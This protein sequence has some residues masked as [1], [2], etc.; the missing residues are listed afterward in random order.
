VVEVS[1]EEVWKKSEKPRREITSEVSEQRKSERLKLG[2][3][4]KVSY[5]IF[6]DKR[7]V[8][9]RHGCTSFSLLLKYSVSMTSWS[10]QT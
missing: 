4:V 3:V 8:T 6:A 2:V 9:E 1:E 10:S 5:T 7:Q